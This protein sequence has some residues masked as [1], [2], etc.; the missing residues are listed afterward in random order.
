[1]VVSVIQE[2]HAK[3]ALDRIALLTRPKTTVIRDGQEQALD[4]GELVQDD[5]LVLRAGDQIVVD[6]PVIDEGR[7]EVDESLLTGESEPIT[8]RIGDWL[9]FRQFL[10]FREHVTGPKVGVTSVAGQ[11]TT[12][13]RAFRRIV[14]PFAAPHHGGYA[15]APPGRA[16]Y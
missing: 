16:L 13:A 15:S 5:V 9:I 12:K 14:T 2:I 6:G 3:L 8:K 10:R 4:P 11:L 1:M 7:I